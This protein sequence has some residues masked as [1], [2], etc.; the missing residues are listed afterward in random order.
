M[1][2][3]LISAMSSRRRRIPRQRRNRQPVANSD[4]MQPPV[5]DLTCD[6]YNFVDLTHFDG[7]SPASVPDTLS[8]PDAPTT[9]SVTRN[10]DNLRSPYLVSDGS[11]SDD[12]LPPVPFKLNSKPRTKEPMNNA[13]A[14]GSRVEQSPKAVCPVCLDSFAEVKASGRQVM[15]TTCGHVFCEECLK[16]VLNENAGGKK[17]PTC[18][19]K[20]SART[21]HLLFI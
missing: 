16:G 5:V 3:D 13:Q 7:S 8:V 2:T 14:N 1:F 15:S 6:D 20:L 19:K 9:R 11:I 4:D 18:R 21:V 10:E 12:E 17:C